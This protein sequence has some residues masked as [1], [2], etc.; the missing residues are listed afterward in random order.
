[1][2]KKL[3]N[4]KIAC[5]ILTWNISKILISKLKINKKLRLFT[6]K[7]EIQKT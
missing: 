4:I 5:I 2:I 6:H 7:Y 3:K 1:M